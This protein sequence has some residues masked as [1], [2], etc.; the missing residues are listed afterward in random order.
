M[1]PIQVFCTLCLLGA[2]SVPIAGQNAGPQKSA[3]VIRNAELEIE[4]NPA[5]GA[6][7]IRTTGK[8]PSSLTASVAAKLNGA[9]LHS[10]DYPRHEISQGS[11]QSSLAVGNTL[12]VTNTG[13]A[14]MPDLIATFTLGETSKFAQVSVEV[15]NTTGKEVAIQAIRAVDAT[16]DPTINLGGPDKFD[17]VLSDSFSEDRPDMLIHDLADAENGMHRAVGSQLIYNRQSGQSLFIGG[18]ASQRWLTVI[19]LHLDGTNDRISSYEVDST[20]TTELEKENSLQDSPLEDQIELSLPVPAGESVS[21][22]PLMI[23]LGGDYHAQL[24]S[25]GALIRE[26]HHAR[27]S[28]PT[29]IGWWSWTA[30]YFGLTEGAALTNAQWLAAH[31]KDFGYKFFHID[32][33]YQFARGEYTTPDAAMI[34][35]GM[36]ALESNVRSLGLTP[37]IWTAPFEV[38]E[39]SWVYANHKDWLVHNAAGQPIPAGFV[40]ERKDQLYM[41]DTTN[42]GAQDYLRQTYTT[43]TRDWG[44]RYIKLDFM[45]DAAIEGFR[46]RPNTTAMEAQRI[47]LQVIRDTVGEG[48]LL[49]KDGSVMLNP[50]GI[51]DTGRISSDT[52]HTFE[53][54]RNSATGIVARYFMNRNFFIS[55]P[56]AF[57]V[58]IQ[59]M[60]RK[61]RPL[62]LDEAKVSITLAAVCG[63]MFE[64]GDDLPTLGADGDRLALVENRELINMARWGHASIPL[65]LMTYPA[66]QGRPS[67]FVLQ[68]GPSRAIVTIFNWSDAPFTRDFKSVVGEKPAETFHRLFGLPAGDYRITYVLDASHQVQLDEQHTTL[69]QPPHSVLVLKFEKAGEPQVPTRIEVV[70][71]PSAQVG[72]PVNFS[73]KMTAGDIPVVGYEW[74]FGD[75]TTAEGETVFHTYTHGGK[76]RITVAAEGIDG[77]TTKIEHEVEAKGNF[78]TDFTPSRNRRF[79]P[80]QPSP[81][82]SG[83]APE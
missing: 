47:G 3:N 40:T 17:R 1:K 29:P 65:D 80:N 62:T 59:T 63:G 75:G 6:Y 50:V 31:L 61:D 4:A 79:Q 51:V 36:E 44:I 34:P 11:Y 66:E 35:D 33:G 60:A 37:G 19:R 42:P 28:A 52:G 82:K 49:D 83:A 24:E 15:R 22:E 73:A 21:S 38:S 2:T 67:V 16:G 7:V 74:E 54:T 30:Y 8:V 57:N 56:D 25:Y 27:V 14:G 43:L 58:S 5:T 48:V 32:E 53:D 18:L 20:G 46:Y 76:F 39:R 71:Q 55:D 9:W 41:L 45:D 81:P 12:T 10:A 78:D 13:R 68:E 23:S 69:L 70:S 64:I 77:N 26:L 72:Q